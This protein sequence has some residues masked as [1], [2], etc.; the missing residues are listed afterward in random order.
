MSNILL[1]KIILIG[2]PPYIH[3][4]V[5]APLYHSYCGVYLW[6]YVYTCLE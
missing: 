2:Y 1:K 5:P 3:K 4:I 6:C